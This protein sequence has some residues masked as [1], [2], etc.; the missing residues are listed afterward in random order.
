MG[1]L[2]WG[3]RGSPKV[4]ANVKAQRRK[5]KFSLILWTPKFN[6]F[7]FLCFFSFNFGKVSY[8]CKFRPDLS[9]P[10][11]LPSHFLLIFRGLPAAPH[12]LCLYLTASHGQLK[13]FP[14]YSWILAAGISLDPWTS[15]V[16]DSGG[17]TQD[18]Q[19]EHWG[20]VMGNTGCGGSYFSIWADRWSRQNHEKNSGLLIPLSRLW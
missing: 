14:N 9:P 20:K 5:F 15:L 16:P 2:R 6:T 7:S 4:N 11:W 3:R 10:S 17:T 18:W 8:R 13:C 19:D 12:G 1:I